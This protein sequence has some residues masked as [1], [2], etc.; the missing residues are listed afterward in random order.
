MGGMQ[1]KIRCKKPH[2]PL[3]MALRVGFLVFDLRLGAYPKPESPSPWSQMTVAVCSSP[4]DRCQSRAWPSGRGG[5]KGR[6]DLWSREPFDTLPDPVLALLE[7]LVE[8][9]R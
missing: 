3:Q 2:L 4:C 9:L 5:R 6:C 8:V 7:Q 1:C